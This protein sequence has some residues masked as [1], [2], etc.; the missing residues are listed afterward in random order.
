M[1]TYGDYND[2]G[3]KLIDI[4]E[5]TIL[6]L[7]EATNANKQKVR[8]LVNKGSI[9]CIRSGRKFYFS[10]SALSRAIDYP[11]GEYDES[12]Y[13][14]WSVFNESIKRLDAKKIRR[15]IN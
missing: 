11:N 13:Q 9:P 6:L 3:P 2:E 12:R 8:R 1:G 5:A 10:K 15:I 4:E 14:G 7:G